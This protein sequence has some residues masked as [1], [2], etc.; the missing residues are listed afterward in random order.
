MADTLVRLQQMSADN[1]RHLADSMGYL[2]VVEVRASQR[3]AGQYE[4]MMD[5]EADHASECKRC[6][7]DHGDFPCADGDVDG[8]VHGPAAVPLC[9][10]CGITIA[11]FGANDG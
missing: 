6:G 9:R 8:P 3:V 4:R 10:H 5:H 11:Y 7:R 2:D 1:L